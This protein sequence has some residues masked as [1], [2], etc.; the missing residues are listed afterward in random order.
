MDGNLF[1]T[2]SDTLN[3]NLVYTVTKR[4]HGNVRVAGI[5]ALT[6]TQADLTWGRVSFAHYGS[7]EPQAGFYFTVMD[8]TTT[9]PGQLF[10]ITVTS[11]D[12]PP[13]VI[14]NLGATVMKVMVVLYLIL[15]S[16]TNTPFL[17]PQAEW[18]CSDFLK[19]LAV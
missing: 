16:A 4:L 2:D 13:T 8:G 14:T 1:T 3:V 17:H 12:D 5:S 10:A 7:E 19:R 11:V 15:G 18:G 6:F 9:L